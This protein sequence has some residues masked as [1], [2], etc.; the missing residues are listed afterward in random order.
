MSE[1]EDPTTRYLSREA[2]L[3]QLKAAE[4]ANFHQGVSIVQLGF[5][6]ERLV[7]ALEQQPWGLANLKR[8]AT[9]ER[10]KAE[11]RALQAAGKKNYEIAHAIG[12]TEKSVRSYLAD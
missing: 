12:R 7:A 5:H 11:A 10:K 8:S 4:D 9:K 1:S 3:R 6:I 2:L